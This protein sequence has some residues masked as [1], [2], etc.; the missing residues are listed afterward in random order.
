MTSGA[1]EY[2]RLRR[3]YERGSEDVFDGSLSLMIRNTE[4]IWGGWSD[5]SWIE[6]ERRR[7]ISNRT[8]NP[9]FSSPSYTDFEFRSTAISCD[10][11]PGQVVHNVANETTTRSVITSVIADNTYSSASYTTG[12]THRTRSQ[13]PTKFI[14]PKRES[15]KTSSKSGCHCQRNMEEL[16]KHQEYRRFMGYTEWYIK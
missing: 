6:A 13:S 4:E 8:D 16:C 1:V 14:I 7:T 15:P 9:T 2:L 10:F 11:G 12:N 3:V 5:Y